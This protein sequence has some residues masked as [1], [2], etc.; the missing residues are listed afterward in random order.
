[1]WSSVTAVPAA[2][3]H[4][5]QHA[6]CFVPSR[7]ARSCRLSPLSNHEDPNWSGNPFVW[8]SQRQDIVRHVSNSECGRCFHPTCDCQIVLLH[9]LEVEKA[10]VWARRDQVSKLRW[11]QVFTASAVQ[12]EW[13]NWS[14]NC[15]HARDTQ[16][17][18]SWRLIS[19]SIHL[20]VDC[21]FSISRLF[22]SVRKLSVVYFS[23]S[24]AFLSLSLSVGCFP[25]SLSAFFLYLSVGFLFSLYQ[26]GF[27]SLF[28]SKFVSLSVSAGVF[29]S[30]SLCRC[31][32]QPIFL[33]FLS[34]SWSVGLFSPLCQQVLFYFSPLCQVGFFLFLLFVSKFFPLLLCQ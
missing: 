1:M 29:F 5:L 30:L 10:S 27:L 20:S 32:C 7:A 31:G 2:T 3:T 12:E 25:L 33:F 11:A 8:V 9:I 22:F 17:P 4:V 18:S 6:S 28:V 24:I 34:L 14:Q 26:Q 13:T 23:L 21:F 16:A 15:T 19:F